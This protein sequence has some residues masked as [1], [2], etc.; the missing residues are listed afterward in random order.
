MKK[1]HRKST[2]MGRSDLPYAQRL[3]LQ[4]Q[5]DI[6]GNREDAAKVALYC[7]SIAM[8][9]LEGIG[10]QRLIRFERRYRLLEE[11]FYQ[12]GMEVGLF[13]AKER[14]EQMGMYISGEI[15]TAPGEGHNARRQEI[16]NHAMQA[17]QA[18]LTVGA[19]AMNDVF[20]FG[21]DRQAR[22]A[23]RVEELTAEYA[24]KGKP[25]LLT[26]MEK[27]GFHVEG[28]RVMFAVDEDGK[29]VRI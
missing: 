25:F 24:Q 8:H 26:E 10:Y 23:N 14:L 20:G 11:E 12:D 13:H 22:I 4:Q 21:A 27:I 5:A 17:T 29:A 16:R 6:A 1:K 3:K 9:E 18:A 2:I 28:S 15:Y 19:I 7:M